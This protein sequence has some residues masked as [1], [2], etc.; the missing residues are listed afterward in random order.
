MTYNYIDS[1]SAVPVAYYKNTSITQ[2][3]FGPDDYDSL[4]LMEKIQKAL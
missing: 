3:A 2:C 4:P 1:V